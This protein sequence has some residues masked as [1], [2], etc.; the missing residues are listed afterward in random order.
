MR[1]QQ[2]LFPR[3]LFTAFTASKTPCRETR[4]EKSSGFQ[5]LFLERRFCEAWGGCLPAGSKYYS[6]RCI[7]L[8]LSLSQEYTLQCVDCASSATSIHLGRRRPSSLENLLRRYKVKRTTAEPRSKRRARRGEQAIFQIFHHEGAKRWGEERRFVETSARILLAETVENRRTTI[9]RRF[10]SASY[11]LRSS[12]SFLKR[13][14]V[15][16]P[17][18]S[19]SRRDIFR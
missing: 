6:R 8:S 4:R 17:R 3:F 13:G 7:E 5:L 11:R 19:Q 18:D 2:F 12:L 10:S 14:F 1:E 16:L 9:H 15:P